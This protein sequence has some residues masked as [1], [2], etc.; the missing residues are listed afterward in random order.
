M[1]FQL[2][3]WQ[4]LSTSVYASFNYISNTLQRFCGSGRLENNS[5]IVRV[6]MEQYQGVDAEF[7]DAIEDQFGSILLRNI[8]RAKMDSVY[9]QPLSS[10]VFDETAMINFPDAMCL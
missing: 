9:S 2:A 1:P 3:C 5:A 4:E 6:L 8:C 10:S 7:Q